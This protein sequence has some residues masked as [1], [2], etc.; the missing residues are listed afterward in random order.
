[1]RKKFDR[2]SQFKIT[3]KRV[4]PPIWRR[5]H[6]PETYTFWDL[7]VAIQ[8]VMGWLDCHLHHFEILNPST[9]MKE[10]I[11]IPDEDFEWD[12]SIL[13]GWKQKISDFFSRDHSKSDYIYDYG[14][15]WEHT[16]KL[17]K[18][19]PRQEDI[20]YPVCIGG[21]RAC[22]PE[23]SGGPWGYEDFLAA[24]A[25]PDHEEH[26]EWLDWVGGSFDPKHFDIKKVVF[27]DPAKRLRYALG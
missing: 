7:H 19:L 2:V 4:K 26:E 17:E 27:A 3:L 24:I 25:N 16:V 5:I 12:R 6:V 14:D 22:P 15:H 18:I 23:D 20:K 10:E 21:K 11:G 9:S 1:M 13:P 8:D